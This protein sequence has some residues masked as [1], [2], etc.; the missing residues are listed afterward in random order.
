MK[1]NI[2]DY[3]N[4][5]KYCWEIRAVWKQ[6]VQGIIDCIINNLGQEVETKVKISSTQKTYLYHH[7]SRE[8][9]IQVSK[10]TV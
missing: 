4:E 2:H 3:Y 7:Y 5:H 1:N 9:W 10:E 8:N 6:V